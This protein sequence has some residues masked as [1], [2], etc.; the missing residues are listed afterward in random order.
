[1]GFICRRCGYCCSLDVRLL[2]EDID[3]LESVGKKDFYHI[4]DGETF[5]KTK[6]GRC[7]F[8]ESRCTVYLHRPRIC[9]HFPVRKDRTMSHFCTQ[10]DDFSARVD[11]NILAFLKKR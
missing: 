1:M 9:R 8:Y 4:L 11:R 6:D 10:N 3:R 5:L 2:K 7:I